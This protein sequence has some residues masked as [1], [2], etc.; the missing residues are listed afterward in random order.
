MGLKKGVF[1]R[2]ICRWTVVGRSGGLV[3][4]SLTA[5]NISQDLKVISSE[6]RKNPNAVNFSNDEASTVQL[7]AMWT[8]SKQLYIESETVR[9]EDH[10][11]EANDGQTSNISAHGHP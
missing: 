9:P 6:L 4:G 8:Q 11:T 2:V 1:A 3:V 5:R 7:A 10:T